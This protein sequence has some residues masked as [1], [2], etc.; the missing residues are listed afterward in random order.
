MSTLTASPKSASSSSLRTLL[1]SRPLLWFFVL[2]F[3][4]TWLFLAP[5]VL[6]QD[7]LGLLPYSVPF[8]LYVALFLA[9]SF[10]G[11]TLA[12]L[13]VTAA[14]E[15]K[16]GVRQF[17][18]RYVQWRVG[19]RWY[20]LTLLGF[21]AIYLLA[22]T[23]LLGAAPWQALFQQWWAVLQA[24]GLGV[25]LFPAILQ[26]GE[27]PGWRGFA[28]T[29]MQT[30]V[31]ALQA[32]LFVGFLHGIWH[33]PIHLLVVGPPAAG[34]FDLTNFLI[35][36]AVVMALT[37]I[38]TWIFNNAQQS[39][40]IAVLSHASFNASQAMIGR[41]LPDQSEQVGNTALIIMVVCAVVLALVTRGKLGYAP[42]TESGAPLRS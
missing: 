20:L 11:P 18:R 22:A 32:S 31:G 4:G 28:Q 8:V 1:A 30:Q 39:I 16:P 38:L 10:T 25:V 34:P 5:M 6:G 41:L 12:A 21:P 33:L 15:G 23:L 19:W 29:R 42:G 40:L 17:L 35:N 9:A 7:G 37:L 24:Y 27:E 3:A 26:W 14:R 2:A 13:V 36:T